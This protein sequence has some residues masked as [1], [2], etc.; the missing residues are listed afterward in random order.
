MVLS[1]KRRGRSMHTHYDHKMETNVFKYLYETINNCAS[2]YVCVGGCKESGGP[3]RFGGSI[4]FTGLEE[5]RPSIPDSC[6]VM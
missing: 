3:R 1:N 2:V 6:D 4:M 5:A